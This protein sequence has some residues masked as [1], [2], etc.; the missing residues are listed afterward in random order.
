MITRALLTVS[1]L[2]SVVLFPWQYAVLLS[3]VAAIVEPFAPLA[4]GIFADTL[5]YTPS[6]QTLP[7]YSILGAC[8]T[9]LAFVLRTR[10]RTSIMWG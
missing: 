3:I 2:T 5:Y 6:I 4:V 1:A 8:G 10:M 7:M 9:V